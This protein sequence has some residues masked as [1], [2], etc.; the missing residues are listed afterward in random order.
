[1]KTILVPT[2][3]SK[4]ALNA[5][6]YAFSYAELTKRKIVLFH[7]YTN[8]SSGLD[9]PFS[10]VHYDKQEAKTDAEERMKKLIKSL[11]KSFPNLAP[12]WVVQP[13]V[14]SHAIIDYVRQN[15]IEMVIMGTTGQGVISSVLIGNTT[16][17]VLKEVPCTIIVI[18]SGAKFKEITKVAIATDLKHDSLL[19]VDE[20]V[21][22]ARELKAEAMFIHVEDF[23]DFNIEK[24][25]QKMAIKIQKQVNYKKI[26][27]SLYKDSEIESGLDLFIKKNKP[28]IFSMVTHHSKFPERLWKTSWTDRM[29]KHISVPLLV[30]HIP[31][32]GLT[33]NQPINVESLEN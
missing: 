9:I 11:S 1:M 7:T 25:L 32:L 14:A 33:K 6:K 26:S 10:G 30:V 16:S 20:V 8:P 27:L 3:F 18:P 12:K 15:K 24:K 13:G 17:T 5:V 19:A 4:G 2:D 28:D 31:K 23:G 29:S 22:F 21:S